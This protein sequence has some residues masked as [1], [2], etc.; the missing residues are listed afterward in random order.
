M[1]VVAT[2]TG[3][4]AST[5]RVAWRLTIEDFADKLGISVR[6]VGKWAADQAFVPPLSMQQ[7]LDTAL[8]QAPPPVRTRFGLLRIDVASAPA[9]QEIQIRPGNGL[10]A[11][12]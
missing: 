6:T 4:V 12:S 10:E 5:L 1:D 9:I 3:G 11:Y 2:W 8:E 7:I